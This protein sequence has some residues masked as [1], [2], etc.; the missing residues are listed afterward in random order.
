MGTVKRPENTV[1]NAGKKTGEMI[2]CK[3]VLSG[4]NDMGKIIAV[5]A[6]FI[7]GYLGSAFFAEW[8]NWPE[9]GPVLAVA[10]MGVFI[11]NAIENKNDK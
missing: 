1:P 5:V 7:V 10:T 9:A 11:L 3:V 6:T 8:M 4:G 2:Q